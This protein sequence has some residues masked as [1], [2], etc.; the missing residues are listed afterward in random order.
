MHL[1][2]SLYRELAVCRHCVLECLAFSPPSSSRGAVSGGRP[3]PCAQPS[4]AQLV[5]PTTEL[6]FASPPVRLS[7]SAGIP[8]MCHLHALALD[9]GLCSCRVTTCPLPPSSG[10][11]ALA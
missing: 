11:L 7:S 8:P 5:L 9:S 4:L 1:V 2:L 10:E 3:F 6:A